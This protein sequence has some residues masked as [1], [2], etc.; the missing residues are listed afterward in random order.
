MWGD[1]VD[2]GEPCSLVISSSSLGRTVFSYFFTYS[3][4]TATSGYN[5]PGG[6][7]LE[8]DPFWYDKCGTYVVTL[9]VRD[10]RI[11]SYTFD[12]KP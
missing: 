6:A 5:F 4:A 1:D 9:Y 3:K 8:P 11:S 12:I 2:D 7:I 10:R